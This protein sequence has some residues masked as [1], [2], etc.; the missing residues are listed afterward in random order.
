MQ[1]GTPLERSTGMG[2]ISSTPA[3][4]GSPALEPA[5]RPTGTRPVAS[6]V[7]ATC[8]RLLDVSIASLMLIAMSPLLL[9]IAVGVKCT[10]RGPVLFR[11]RRIGLDMEE[12]TLLKFR[13]MRAGASTAPHQEFVARLAAGG[14][15]DDQPIKKL[16][17]DSRVTRLGA[18]LRHTSLDELP[19][20]LNVIAGDMSL[21]G[22]RPA[23]GYE[24]ALYRPEHFE[25]FAVLPGMTGLWQV[26]GRCTLGFMEMLDLDVDYARRASL[27]R[28][29]GILMRT[30]AVLFTTA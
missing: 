26:S 4:D 22:P 23:L 13:S 15:P 21:V 11:Q 20:L 17:L 30:P 25:R 3:L 24:L 7:R 18:F 16:T 10:S 27:R 28:D 29:L 12:F 9:A 8:K 6:A 2:P 14:V 1:I 5:T 19:Q